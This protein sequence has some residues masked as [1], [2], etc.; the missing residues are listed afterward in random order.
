MHIGSRTYLQVRSHLRSLGVRLS[1]RHAPQEASPVLVLVAVS[2]A[3]LL[4]ILE[5]DLHQSELQVLGLL[6]N[7]FGI[8]PAFMSP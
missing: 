7:S 6:G 1:S 3:L 4:A 2:L 8:D 5:I